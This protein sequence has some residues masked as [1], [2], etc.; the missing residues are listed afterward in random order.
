MLGLCICDA[1]GCTVGFEKLCV[2]ASKSTKL[3]V[4]GLETLVSPLWCTLESLRVYA[5]A[6]PL[7]IMI[8]ARRYT[9][10]PTTGK[11]ATWNAD[12]GKTLFNICSLR[13]EL[14]P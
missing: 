10:I 2:V 13:Q 14:S 8:E 4:P 7:F 1:D 5:P 11:F 6:K 9:S 3:G 12:N